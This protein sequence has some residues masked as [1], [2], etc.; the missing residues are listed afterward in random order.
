MRQE[1]WINDQLQKTVSRQ[2]PHLQ[3]LPPPQFPFQLHADRV[4]IWFRNSLDGEDQL[5]QRVAFALS[6]IMVVS[7]LGALSNLP[8]DRKSVV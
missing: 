4:D 7:Q 8:L 1:E 3:A 6:E 2:L 5:R